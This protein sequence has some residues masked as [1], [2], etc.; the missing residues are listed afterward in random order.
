MNTERAHELLSDIRRLAG[1][2]VASASADFDDV[3]RAAAIARRAGE[4][5]VE[6]DAAA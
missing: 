5:G 4:L 1:E 3:D 2:I 6:L